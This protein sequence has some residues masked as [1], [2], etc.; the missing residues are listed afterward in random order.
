MKKSQYYDV[1]VQTRKAKEWRDNTSPSLRDLNTFSQR[2]RLS[3]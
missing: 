2:L 3:L 1:V